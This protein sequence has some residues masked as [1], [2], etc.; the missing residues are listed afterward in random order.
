M[1]EMALEKTKRVP[2]VAPKAK[3]RAPGMGAEQEV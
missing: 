1:L 3:R 2:L